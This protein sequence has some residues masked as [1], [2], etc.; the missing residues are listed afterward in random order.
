MVLSHTIGNDDISI[1]QYLIQILSP[2]KSVLLDDNI[3]TLI[4]VVISV[5]SGFTLVNNNAF[6]EPMR[7]E[8]FRFSII[9]YPGFPDRR[10]R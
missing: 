5:G 9:M 6:I 1:Y 10:V 3:I 4:L 8:G 7:R 2:S